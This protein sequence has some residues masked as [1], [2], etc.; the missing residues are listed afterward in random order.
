MREDFIGRVARH[1]AHEEILPGFEAASGGSAHPGDFARDRS[2]YRSL[3]TD[4]LA[5]DFQ[6][7]NEVAIDASDIREGAGEDEFGH[8]L[9]GG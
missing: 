6:G 9:M 4:T 8:G 3:T 5:G 2:F 1:L 7:E